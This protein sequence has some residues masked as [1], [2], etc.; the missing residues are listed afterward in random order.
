MTNA[1]HKQQY[2]DEVILGFAKASP[3]KTAL[4]FQDQSL[5]YQELSQRVCKMSAYLMVSGVRRG[6][7][8][9]VCLPPCLDVTVALLAVT[10]LGAIY[11]PLDPEHP[12]SQIAERLADIQPSAVIYNTLSTTLFSS[13]AGHHLV[14]DDSQAFE[15]FQG[16]LDRPVPRSFDDP[17]CIFFT[18]GTTGKAK[19]V[20]GSFTALREAIVSPARYLNFTADDTLNSIARYAWSISMLEMMAPLVVGGTSLI[21]DRAQALNLDWLAASAEQCTAFHCPPALLKTLVEHIDQQG[22]CHSRRSEALAEVRLVWYGGD[23]FTPETIRLI[24]KVFPNAQVGTAYGCTEIFGLSHC[25]LYPKGHSVEQVLIGE[26]VDSIYQYLLDDRQ[27][28]VA[29]GEAGE[30]FLGGP[31]VAIEYWQQPELT[32]QKYIQ[33]GDDRL[34]A[35]GDFGRLV[36]G[37]LAFMQRQDNQVKIRG[38]RVE[39]GEVEFHLRQQEGVKD[40]AVIARDAQADTKELCGFV[41]FKEGCHSDLA[42]LKRRLADAMPDYMVPAHIQTLDALPYTENFKVDR[43]ALA[44]Q[45]AAPADNTA[46]SFND[47]LIDQLLGAWQ[48]AAR[49]SPQSVDDSFFTIGGDSLSA[50]KLATILTRVL[51]ERVEVADIY[52]R[53]TLAKQA[54]GFSGHGGRQDSGD[55]IGGGRDDSA[56]YASS[57]QKGLVFRELLEKRTASITCT[58]YI[59]RKSG[60]STPIVRAAMKSLVLR[61][62]TLRTQFKF[63][64]GNIALETQDDVLEDTISIQRMEGLWSVEGEPGISKQSV[65]FDLKAGPL[66]CAVISPLEKGGELLQLTAHHAAADDNSMGRLAQDFVEI[67]DAELRGRPSELLPLAEPYE[68]FTTEQQAKLSSGH[69]DA[70]ALALCQRLEAHLEKQD[71]ALLDL[72]Q[73]SRDA[74]FSMNHSVD[75]G[76]IEKPAV[77]D[78]EADVNDTLD[79]KATSTIKFTEYVAA[80]SWAMAQV[81]GRDTFVF[82]AHVALR[83]D[84]AERPLVGMFVNLLPVFV[85]VDKSDSPAQHAAKTQH[86]FE[87]AMSHSDLP[88][89][90]VLSKSA[91]LKR[92]GGFPFDAFVNELRFDNRYLSGYEDILVQRSFSTDA[93]E[94]SMSLIRQLSGDSVKVECPGVEGANE[95][96]ANMLDIMS[97]FL[98]ELAR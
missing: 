77:G 13:S 14:L 2:L 43:K 32:E 97:Q 33:V 41:V 46:V 69:Y 28:P 82:C 53:P 68:T 44:K 4:L 39:L 89:E 8:V 10:R 64:R 49:V 57:G 67:Y 52:L 61:F 93:N 78:I 86:D 84:E 22:E 9:G 37:Q 55:T 23:T 79:E 38:I 95:N 83:R 48:E 50:A 3:E 31:R 90:H 51:G 94:I 92:L 36:D 30:I 18:S 81:F 29:E 59:Y 35:T 98:K 11:A 27:Q 75:L 91:A 71:G 87:A 73:W 54:Q 20:V 45:S 58:R 88:Y 80:L 72:S 74:F 70:D 15:G 96:V 34:Y 76:H 66:I 40:A 60:F 85:R 62:P 5:S 47:P 56:I 16:A 63:A 1:S 42:L 7:F 25:H 12:Q 19:G 6:D 17:A 65:R 21:L 26:P 24:Q